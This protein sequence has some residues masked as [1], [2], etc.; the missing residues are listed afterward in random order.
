MMEEM[1][2]D[3]WADDPAVRDAILRDAANEILWDSEESVPPELD[4]F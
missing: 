3:R 2:N 4:D 1:M